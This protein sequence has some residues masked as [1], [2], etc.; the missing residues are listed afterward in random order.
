M[1]DHKYTMTMS[2]Q[3]LKHLGLNLYS[4]IAAVVSE[5]VAN[6]YDADAT[7]VNIWFEDDKIV[8]EDDGHGM[9]LGDI[10][11]K[12]LCV[13][14]T[15]RENGEEKSPKFNRDVMGRK[16]IG[17]LS[18]FSIARNVEIHTTRVSESG[19]SH[20]NGL[21]L[22]IKDIEEEIK[23]DGEYHPKNIPSDQF[24]IEKGTRIILT[25]IKKKSISHTGPFLRKR[26]ARRFSV[27]GD[28]YNFNVKIDDEPITMK[29]RDF[30]KK[31]L[32]MWYIGDENKMEEFDFE[33]ENFLNGEID[34]TEFK[35]RGW[36]GTVDKPSDLEQDGT[37]NNNISVICRG[38]MAQQDIL[39]SYNEGGIYASYLIGEIHADFLDSNENDD[40]AT[41][42]R[43]NI[44]EDDPRYQA[45]LSHVYSLL[46]KIQN[47][48]TQYR[49]EYAEK[50]AVQKAEDLSPTLKDWYDS[51]GNDARK[52]HA[53]KLFA[54][55][56]S[57]H[58]DKNEEKDKKRELYRHGILAFEKLK[59]RESLDRLDS[60]ETE[61]DIKLAAIFS[62][63]TDIEANQYFDIASGRV[64]V[65]KEFQKHIDANDKE[66]ILQKYLFENL[67]LLNPSWD[68]AT[69]GTAL[70]E[71]RVEKAFGKVV[72]TLTKEER[73]GRFDIRYRTS[74]GT[75]VIVELKKYSASYKITSGMLHD[76]INKYRNALKKCLDDAGEDSS[77]IKSYIIIGDA[78]KKEDWKDAKEMLRISGAE[79]L[80]YDT[81]L[82]ESYKA[83]E[84]Y[85]ERQ[86]EVSKIRALIDKI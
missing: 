58:F 24:E 81:L 11:D 48:W 57:L 28:A 65:I 83:Y 38:K 56:E 31:V 26:I 55:I 64:E 16:G 25:D 23:K 12:F 10:N 67:W 69:A 60:L 66:A 37:M 52:Q 86:K 27:L 29:D 6:S 13:G 22:N 33:K 49:K 5:V 35:I 1:P 36:I 2:L 46:K 18:L 17:K 21:L 53:K 80:H 71:E 20:T 61:D 32:F 63:L 44:N 76:Q 85:M 19:E 74:A 54:T 77:N 4:N 62:D 70:M 45:L 41:S 73:V 9:T 34:G 47:V 59:L 3:V 75:H 42:S 50:D 15:R 51:L 40:I 43:Q 79:L 39:R 78:L 30:F 8:I 82:Q 84:T 7:S 14:Y 72:N 68:R